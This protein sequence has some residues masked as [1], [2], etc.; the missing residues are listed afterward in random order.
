MTNITCTEATFPLAPTL[1]ANRLNHDP[2][3]KT[4]VTVSIGRV[5]A[6]N[7]KALV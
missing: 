1:T 5:L 7:R 4:N 3:G 6:W 2:L